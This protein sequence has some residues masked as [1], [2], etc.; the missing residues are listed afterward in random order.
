MNKFIFSSIEKKIFKLW[1]KYNYS[2]NKKK[3]YKKIFSITIPPPNITGKLHIGHILNVVLQ[4]ILVRYKKMLNYKISWIIGTDHASIATEHKIKS[5]YKN[6]KNKKKILKKIKKW[7]IKYT[8]IIINQLI[9]FGCMINTTKKIEF[10]LNKKFKK[11]IKNI[12]NI[13]FYKKYIYKKYKFINWDY[14]INTSLSNEEIKKKKIK[15][16]L[17]Y[18]KYQIF[19]SNKY[20]VI[21]TTR[22]ETMFGDTAICLSKQNKYF[23]FLKK[24]K[25]IN[26]INKKIIPIIF[27]NII[28]SNK[29]SGI[30]KVTP[31]ND[32]IDFYLYKKYKLNIINIY[33]K[34]GKLNN[35]CL[36][37]KNNKILKARKKIINYLLLNNKIIDIQKYNY[38][39]YYS[40]KNNNIIQK[41][42]SLQWFLNIKKKKFNI[43]NILN[44]IFF[45]PKNTKN[46]C[47]N[48]LKNIK[49]WNISRNLIWGHKISIFYYK[50][51]IYLKKPHK[52]K[53]KKENFILDTWFSSCM[54]PTIIFDNIN[55]PLNKKFKKYYPLDIIITG[56]DI[57]FC[58]ILRM[59]IMNYYFNKKIPFKNV[60]FTGLIKNENKIKISKSL[61]NTPNLKILLKKYGVDNLRLSV[62]LNNKYGKDII[63]KKSIFLQSKNILI[64]IK[65][66]YIFIKNLNINKKLKIYKYDLENLEII[67]KKM[68][69]ILYKN[70]KLMKKYLI[71]KSVKLICDF[72]K[73]DF[74]NFFLNNIKKFILNNN[75]NIY[76][77]N[78]I[79]YI[80]K[81]ILKLLHPI[82]P[83]FTDYLYNKIYKKN[84]L[85]NKKYPTYI[86]KKNIKNI[87]LLRLII[88]K[89]INIKKKYKINNFNLFIYKKIKYLFFLKKFFNIKKIYYKNIK[90]KYKFIPLFIYNIILLIIIKKNIKYNYKK[91]IFY[92]KKYL[93]FCVNK[94]KNKYFFNKL[95]NKKKIYEINKIKNLKYKIYFLNKYYY[96]YNLK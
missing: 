90:K 29:G 88:K 70:H 2:I 13:L 34:K 8:N 59:I 93:I 50:N 7:S 18:I 68:K 4:D 67:L 86:K 81:N 38:N 30:I 14:K 16:Y 3:K 23:N 41:I 55:K 95:S 46:E 57:L 47:L 39:I 74:S 73:E 72:I 11:S 75:I 53:I 45:Y 76:L 84:I 24:K 66:I 64:K 60:F 1:N 9:N 6:I 48:W 91:K 58:W 32:K 42:P 61:N 56:K 40:D 71:F 87:L 21:A 96:L 80:Y 31:Y 63:Y 49:D 36:N 52:K 78:K 25:V 28:N 85:L 37:Y 27:D 51:K 33:N 82:I 62:L 22:P 69:Y 77:Y 10:T 5:I 92:Y 12:F 19:K 79:L 94:L 43:K 35:N 17:Y 65:N 15:G 89:I 44:K 26:P 54:W 83:F 20:I